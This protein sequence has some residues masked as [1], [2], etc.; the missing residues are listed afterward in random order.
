MLL[1]K[2]K[3]AEIRGK[4]DSEQCRVG[5]TLPRRLCFQHLIRPNEI[6]VPAKAGTQA[7]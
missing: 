3:S 5:V 7:K 6:V 2:I 1:A 4:P